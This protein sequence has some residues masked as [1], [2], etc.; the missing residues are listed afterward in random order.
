MA[1][2][3][4]YSQ[5]M[6]EPAA[7]EFERHRSRCFAIAYRMLG[8]AA[9][10]E[11]IVQEAWLR[12]QRTEG[13]VT[14]AAWLTTTVTRLCLDYLESARVRR[15]QYVGPWL[16]E[17]IAT[18]TDEVD[19]DSISMAFLL[20][21]ERL[22]PA[23]RAV[24]LLRKV[25]DVDY[26]EIAGMLGKSETAVRQLF[27]RAGEHVEAARPRY[28]PSK[29]QH[30]RLLTGFVMAVQSGELGPIETMLAEDVRAWTDGGGRARAAR[31]VVEG[32]TRVAKLFAGLVKKGGASG[33][34]PEIREINGWPALVLLRGD[35]LVQVLTIETDGERI[36]ATHSVLNPDKLRAL[37]G[38]ARS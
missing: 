24:F 14:A 19:P 18:D 38:H 36:L 25:F 15:E 8:S 21:L 30:L 3:E 22:S 11:D 20:L 7:E 1:E 37:V 32:R 12:W 17:P 26:A 4:R 10:A 16:P 2:E 27:H 5:H 31:N 35:E 28:A 34:R 6:A 9:E 29:E 13:I 23:E 33:L